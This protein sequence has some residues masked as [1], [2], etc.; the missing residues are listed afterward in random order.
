MTWRL[1]RPPTWLA[2]K[3]S[4]P[5]RAG[6]LEEGDRRLTGTKALWLES[7][8]AMGRDR[9]TLLSRLREACGRTG[10][11]WALKEMASRLWGYISK[12]WARKV[13]MA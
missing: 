8:L 10:R 12:G 3:P 9:R 5:G 2:H 11:A 6:R 13:R 1:R 7:P 4:I